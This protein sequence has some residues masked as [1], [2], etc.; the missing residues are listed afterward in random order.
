LLLDASIPAGTQVAVE[1]RAADS[2]KLVVDEPWQPEPRL[3]MRD[4][5]SEVPFYRAPLRAAADHTGTWELL[6]QNAVGRYL[7][8]RV[9]LS[10]PAR[11]RRDCKRCVSYYPRFSYLREY[12]PAAYQDDAVSTS[13]LDRYWQ[14]GGF[15]HGP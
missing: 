10:V 9:T 1:S 2:E 14:H 6:F 11:I 13:F 5:G 15:P 3:Y 12:L 7:Q 4:D 8:L